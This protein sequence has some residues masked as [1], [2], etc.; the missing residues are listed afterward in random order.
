MSSSPSPPRRASFLQ[1][2]ETGEERLLPLADDLQVLEI[3]WLGATNLLFSASTADAFGLY[4]T[5]IFGGTTRK[6]ADGAWR[7]AV[8]PDGTGIAYL[9]GVPSRI[10]TVSGPEGEDPRNVLDLGGEGSVWEIAW[11]PDGRWLLVGIWGGAAD[12]VLEAVNVESGA[13]K[14]VLADRRFRQSW[15]GFLPFFWT[16]D[17]RLVFAWR[18][19]VPNQATANLWQIAID[20]DTATVQGDPVRLTQLA[21]TN[22][23]DLSATVDGQRLAFLQERSQN[24]VL[25][26]QL[27]DGGRRLGEVLRLTVDERQDAPLGWSPDGR[28]LF[29]Q[30]SRAGTRN[31]FRTVLDGGRAEFVAEKVGGQHYL[32]FHRDSNTVLFWSGSELVRVPAA[33][34]PAETLLEAGVSP[35][36]G[37]DAA[38]DRCLGG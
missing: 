6:L 25:V 19:P 5:S 11:S 15:R 27:E 9:E 24:D 33:G 13:R 30:S 29:F 4:K 8:I 32:E 7:A 10:V 28:T 31:L 14:K 20:R 34:G 12:T 26:A 2:V 35:G 16:A 37:C 17:D 22:P 1:L 23:K 18:E 38:G 21:S 36:I 3:D